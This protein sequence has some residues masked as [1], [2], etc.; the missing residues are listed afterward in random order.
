[1]GKNCI[2]S[3]GI[4]SHWRYVMRHLMWYILRCGNFSYIQEQISSYCDLGFQRSKCISQQ[5][6]LTFGI[7]LLIWSLQSITRQGTDKMW[8]EWCGEWMQTATAPGS[9]KEVTGPCKR[10]VHRML[11]ANSSYIQTTPNIGSYI[12]YEKKWR[13]SNIKRPV[14]QASGRFCHAVF[15]VNRRDSDSPNSTRC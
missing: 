10:P 7:R 3:C 2:L 8:G 5:V 14:N 13:R 6:L 15:H 1:M 4:L 12:T 11:I 9:D